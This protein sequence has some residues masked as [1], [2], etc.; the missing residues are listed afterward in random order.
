MTN[1]EAASAALLTELR[2]SFDQPFARAP[3]SRD[4]SFVDLLAIRVAGAPC[5]LR[6]SQV[7]GLH[8]D[9][10]I[11]PLATPVPELLGMAGFRGNIVPVYSL[12][13]LL[14]YSAGEFPRWLALVGR[15]ETVGLAFDDF[16]GHW[17]I[18]E[19]DATAPERAETTSPHLH[20]VAEIDGIIR[21]IIDLGSVLDAI[22]KRAS[23]SMSGRN[24]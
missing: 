6:L 17:R 23:M 11:V 3:Q 24:E 22:R 2:Q 19:K 9:R 20:E 13:M 8:V 4:E 12:R 10:R 16:D 21:P 14:G 5:A 18:P 1:D 7:S 15:D